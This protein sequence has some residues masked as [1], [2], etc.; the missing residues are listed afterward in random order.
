[1]GSELFT[2]RTIFPTG[3]PEEFSFGVTYRIRG[4]GRKLVW[5]LIDFQDALGNSQF[6]LR[7]DGRNKQIGIHVIDRLDYSAK[8]LVFDDR[9][10]RQVHVYVVLLDWSPPW[11]SNSIRLVQVV[12]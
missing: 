3:L 4:K 11:Y 5:N 9:K 2:H 10:V 12:T 8:L 7:M 1:M 6:A